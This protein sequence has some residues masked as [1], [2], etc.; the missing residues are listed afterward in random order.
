MFLQTSR[1]D[2]FFKILFLNGLCYFLLE[3]VLIPM[4]F[5]LTRELFLQTR[6]H[7]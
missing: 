4:I 6:T 3:N 1:Q 7:D 2:E 5:N